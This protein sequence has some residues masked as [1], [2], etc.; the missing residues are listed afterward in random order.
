MSDSQNLP[1]MST[2]VTKPNP[3]ILKWQIVYDPASGVNSDQWWCIT[4]SEGG[5]I[6]L[7]GWGLAQ[8]G[9][10][11]IMIEVKRN[12]LVH[13]YAHL[14][15]TVHDYA[16][17]REKSYLAKDFIHQKKWLRTCPDGVGRDDDGEKDW[18]RILINWLMRHC[19]YDAKNWRIKADRIYTWKRK[20]KQPTNCKLPS[21]VFLGSYDQNKDM[22]TGQVMVGSGWGCSSSGCKWVSLVK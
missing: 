3:T 5:S 17:N 1:K 4:Q 12:D 22:I 15:S 7:S 14:H 6:S 9:V 19:I 18:P 21:F 8:M 13:I 2:K 10:G 20:L 11:V 16:R